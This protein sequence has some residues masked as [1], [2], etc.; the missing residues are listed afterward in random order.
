[1]LSEDTDAAEIYEKA[2]SRASRKD[3]GKLDEFKRKEL[4]K[5]YNRKVGDLNLKMNENMHKKKVCDIL[6]K[7]RAELDAE[8][9]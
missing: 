1:M 7:Q 8:Y 5:E 9:A 2:L 3:W 6:H 4:L